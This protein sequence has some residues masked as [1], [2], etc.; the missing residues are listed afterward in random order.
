MQSVNRECLYGCL[1]TVHHP[2][3]RWSHLYDCYEKYFCKQSPADFAQCCVACC[4]WF[5]KPEEWTSHY[6]H[7][8][9]KPDDL[10]RCD[11]LVFRHALA[12][13]AYCPFCLG[14]SSLKPH[15]RMKQFLDCSKWDSHINSYLSSEVLS[16]QYYCRHPAC[17]ENLES[18]ME[19]K[20]HLEDVHCIL[21][22]R[23]KKRKA[24]SE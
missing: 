8:L 4:C 6:K 12:K 2:H 7:H 22:L 5:T 23:G 24:D 19:L 15:E 16:N 20:W 3:R 13:A 10:L 21:P 14:D 17:S 1:L 9:T 18:L 11:L